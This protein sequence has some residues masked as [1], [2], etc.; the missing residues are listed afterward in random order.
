MLDP[1]TGGS[2]GPGAILGLIRAGQAVTRAQLMQ[3]TGL[4]RSTVAQRLELL[5][6]SGLIAAAGA[7]NSTGGRPPEAFQINPAAGVIL[8]AAIGAASMQIAVA[9]MQ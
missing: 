8:I 3:A 5:L 7:E 4:S 2:N 9:D 6:A 1:N